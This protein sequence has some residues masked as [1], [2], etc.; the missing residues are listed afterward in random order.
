MS[1]EALTVQLLLLVQV[2][3]DLKD[4]GTWCYHSTLSY[5]V[6]NITAVEMPVGRDLEFCSCHKR[7]L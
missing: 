3:L 5:G 2:A 7:A 4:I 1:V 6:Q